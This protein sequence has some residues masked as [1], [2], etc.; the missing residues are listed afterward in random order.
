MNYGSV[1]SGVEAASLA[2]EHLGWK[3]VFFSEVEPF[4]AAVLMQRFGATKPLRPLDPTQASDEKTGK[5][6]FPGRN[7]SPNCQMGGLYLISAILP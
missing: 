2:W 6:A 4:P 7:R 1:C 3:P 5:H